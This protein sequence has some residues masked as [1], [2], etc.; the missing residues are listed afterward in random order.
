MY[1][2]WGVV[3]GPVEK[4]DISRDLSADMHKVESAKSLGNPATLPL[5]ITDYHANDTRLASMHR[6]DRRYGLYTANRIGGLF[7]SS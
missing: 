4:I 5:H 7:A 3:A 6:Y 1:A 2:Q